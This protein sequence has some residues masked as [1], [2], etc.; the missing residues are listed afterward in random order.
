VG[1]HGP[2]ELGGL[3]STDTEKVVKAVAATLREVAGWGE[4]DRNPR[5]MEAVA[6]DVEANWNDVCCPVCQ[7]VTCDEGCPLEA[8]RAESE[9][10]RTHQ[11]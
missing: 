10:E 11:L 7:E 8:V 3:V 5:M 4:D 6:E 9:S 2:A 1:E